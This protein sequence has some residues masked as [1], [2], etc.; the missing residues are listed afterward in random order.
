[1]YE[2]TRHIVLFINWMAYG[3]ARRGWVARAVLPLTSF[4]L[5]LRALRCLM[6]LTK[7]GKGTNDGKNFAAT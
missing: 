3:K 7:R 4:R 6:L 2:G 1:M 5:Y